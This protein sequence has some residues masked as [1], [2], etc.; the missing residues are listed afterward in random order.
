[1]VKGQEPSGQVTIPLT[2]HFLA[3]LKD[4][5]ALVLGQKGNRHR[6]EGKQTA[7]FMTV[8]C[9]PQEAISWQKQASSQKKRNQELCQMAKGL[10]VIEKSGH[11]GG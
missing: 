4:E 7:G 10:W 1:M 5:V 2:L 9:R 8:G 6:V 11:I 3:Q